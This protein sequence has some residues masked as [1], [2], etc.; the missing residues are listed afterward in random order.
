MSIKLAKIWVFLLIF[1]QFCTRYV[2][3]ALIMHLNVFLR[4]LLG[5]GMYLNSFGYL[6]IQTGSVGASKGPRIE[7]FYCFCH[8][9]SYFRSLF[10]SPCIQCIQM[11]PWGTHQVL[12][13][14]LTVFGSF[15]ID[16]KLWGLQKGPE[17]SIS[18]QKRVIGR[19]LMVSQGGDLNLGGQKAGLRVWETSQ[20][21]WKASR[22]I[23]RSARGSER[24][25]GG[26]EKPDWG[27]EKPAWGSEGLEASQRISLRI[28]EAMWRV[29][30][31]AR[32]SERPAKGSRGQP[33]GLRGQL[34]GLRG[35]L[36]G[37]GAI[38]RVWEASQGVWE[39]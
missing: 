23:K 31:P 17:L 19:G 14:I 37:Q 5:T 24:P 25:A 1:S 7:H 32:R 3:S 4:Y 11:F 30:R 28:W 15:Q 33:E 34:E 22:K 27:S 26:S 16:V 18:T 29:K 35:Q 9:L 13:C 8:F 36:E 21:V 12:A 20:R 38:R 2:L 10:K 39:V 6:Q